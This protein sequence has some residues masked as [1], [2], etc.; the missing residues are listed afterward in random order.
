MGNRFTG[1]WNNEKVVGIVTP[2][3]AGAGITE[4]STPPS[5]LRR[6]PEPSQIVPPAA[7]KKFT[8]YRNESGM[9]VPASAMTWLNHQGT[10]IREIN[11]VTNRSV[12]MPSAAAS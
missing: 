12:V 6:M 5:S 8:G 1:Y 3:K 11:S 2:A 10:A 4:R 9:T 7:G